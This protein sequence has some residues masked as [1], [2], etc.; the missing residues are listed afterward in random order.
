MRL[1][2]LRA[3]N[4]F[5]LSLEFVCKLFLTNGQLD[6]DGEEE[7]DGLV[8]GGQVDTAVQADQEDQLHQQGGVHDGVGE[9]GTKPDN[10]INKKKNSVCKDGQPYKGTGGVAWR[11]SVEEGDCG[12]R[13]EAG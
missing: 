2:I 12:A 13:E 7:E 11:E 3:V 4:P 6:K 5:P 8:G 1:P 10:I 9:A